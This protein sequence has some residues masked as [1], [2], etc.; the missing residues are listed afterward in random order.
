LALVLR[1]IFGAR[2]RRLTG[3]AR[4]HRAARDRRVGSSRA[5]GNWSRYVALVDVEAENRELR[6]NERLRKNSRR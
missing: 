1:A 6:D 3:G 5:S 4:D 2:R